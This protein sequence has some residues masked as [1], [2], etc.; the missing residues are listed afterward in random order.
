MLSPGLSAPVRLVKPRDTSDA[1]KPPLVSP[2][3]SQEPLVSP[4]ITAP[5]RRTSPPKRRTSPKIAG[6]KGII[7]N[8][9]LHYLMKK[10][11]KNIKILTV[12]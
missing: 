9:K 6:G 11:Y 8:H 4:R 5:K 7:K 1:R 10:I 3:K 12:S 2:R